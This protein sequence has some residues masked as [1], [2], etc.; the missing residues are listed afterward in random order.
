MPE[1]WKKANGTSVF[2]KG[3]KDPGNCS[4][5]F[6]GEVMECLI[7]KDTCSIMEDTQDKKVITSS[8]H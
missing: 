6:P 8:Q 1:N 4:L 3:K 2:K 7:M 5:S